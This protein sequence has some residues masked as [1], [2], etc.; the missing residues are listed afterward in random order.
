MFISNKLIAQNAE[1]PKLDELFNEKKFQ[2]CI[3][4]AE[5]YSKKESKEPYPVYF[6]SISYF[7]LY[8]NT[9]DERN[10][11]K[12]LT[13]ALIEANSAKAKDSENVFTNRFKSRFEELH[14]E[15]KKFANA[16]YA[17]NKQSSKSLYKYL[18]KVFSDTTHQYKE[19]YGLLPVENTNTGTG[20]SLEARSKIGPN[21]T[22]E[23][24]LKQG[25]WRKIYPNGNVAYEVRFKDNK[26]VGVMKRYHENGKLNAVL[27]YGEDGGDFCSVKLYSSKEKLVAEGFY[28]GRE[29]DSTW[30]YYS[31]DMN[32][33]EAEA[34]QKRLSVIGRQIHYK[35]TEENYKKGKKHGKE[36]KFYP[37]GI[38]AHLVTWENDI[39]NGSEKEYFTSGEVKLEF[40]N[41]N[42]RRYGAFNQYFRNGRP[43]ITGYYV[44]GHRHGKWTYYTNTGEIDKE[45][46]YLYGVAKNQDE[47]DD[48]ETELLN[49]FEKNKGQLDDPENYRNNPDEFIRKF[50]R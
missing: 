3:D 16:E 32:L 17:Q 36:K 30:I 24:G 7:E 41:H 46:T 8:K 20:I 35:I 22:D 5:K 9:T 14:S 23:N 37:S 43:E 28:D 12:Y 6:Q 13:K 2:K 49:E 50:R 18:A 25:L 34:E 19:L 33:A 42:G 40:R 39:K 15:T 48:E 1:F 29:K 44:G 38:V 10:K 45:I 27:V 31:D 47:L 26:P 21:V 11:K 4:K